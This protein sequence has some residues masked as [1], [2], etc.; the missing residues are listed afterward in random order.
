MR[1][2]VISALFSEYC[3]YADNLLKC[4]STNF[5]KIYGPEKLV[6]NT[7]SHLANYAR[8]FGALDIVSCF[9]LKNYLGILKRILR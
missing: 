9:P 8:Q 5:V 6:W 4:Y 3:K 1:I 7:H 2:I